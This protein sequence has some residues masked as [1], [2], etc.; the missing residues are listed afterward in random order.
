[1]RI[2]GWKTPSVF[3]RCAIVTEGDLVQVADRLQSYL[4]GVEREADKA[5]FK[6]TF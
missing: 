5:T 2:G 1:M 6:A 3:R 4:R